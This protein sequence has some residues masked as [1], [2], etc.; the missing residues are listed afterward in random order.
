MQRLLAPSRCAA[1]LPSTNYNQSLLAKIVEAASLLACKQIVRTIRPSY[2]NGSREQ[3]RLSPMESKVDAVDEKLV[4]MQRQIEQMA[5]D[6][7]EL[8]QSLHGK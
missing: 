4:I 1:T 2:F 5:S 7:D 8:K 3:L 6:M